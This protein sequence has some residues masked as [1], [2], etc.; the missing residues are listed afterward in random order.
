VVIEGEIDVSNAREIGG[1]LRGALTNHDTALV[2]DLTPTTYIDSAGINVLFRLGLELR[3]RQQQLH[4]IV[5]PESPI[6]RVITIVGLGEAVPTHPTRD[7]ALAAL[8]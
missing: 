5:A 4:V 3:E 1:R 6:A 8:A 2:V 7:A